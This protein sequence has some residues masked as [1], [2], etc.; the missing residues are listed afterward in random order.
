MVI[1]VFPESLETLVET[2]TIADVILGVKPEGRVPGCFKCG[3]GWKTALY[4][5]KRI[6]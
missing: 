2:I 1:Q 4:H 3:I 5:P 6:V